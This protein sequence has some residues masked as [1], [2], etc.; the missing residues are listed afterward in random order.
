MK[1]GKMSNRRILKQTGILLACVAVGWFLKARLTPSQM[2]GAMMGAGGDPYVLVQEA[3]NKDITPAQTFIARV[4]AIND[5]NIIPQVSGYIDEV[6]F[7]EGSLVKEGDLLFVIEQDRYIAT[8]EL[9]KA[10]LE[11][12]VANFTALE[13]DYNRQKALNKQKFASEA[14]LDNAYSNML[15]AKAS[16]AEAQAN[17]DL[18]KI[19]LNHTEIRA[20][21]T[22]YIGKALITKGNYVSSSTGTLAKI[23][24]TD[25]IRIAFSVTDKQFTDF[26]Q[27]K[28]A[29]DDSVYNRIILP[30]GQNLVKKPIL[31]Y[32][33]NSVNTA[34]STIPIYIEFLNDDG[35][36]IPG[37]YVNIA[38]SKEKAKSGI[39]ISQA[40]LA[41]DENGNY[42][43]VVNKDNLV[44]QRR[45]T[46]GGIVE[47]Q[48]VVTKG[49]EDGEKVI[50][51]GL[52]KV[53][54]GQKVRTGMIANKTST[55]E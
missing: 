32:S 29:V 22:G 20:P 7:K 50:I 17:Y 48:Q 28:K 3:M 44:Q 31:Y 11:K 15:Q 38:L 47:G 30:N 40:S 27:D 13:K 12:E 42:V 9:R 8:L 10:N 34:T 35:L 6:L 16:I 41:Q 46:L 25:P 21:F 49:L 19:D 52:Q 45:V 37:G 24:Q 43:M 33:D 26:K 54:D 14:T 53:R 5:V 4:E 2:M 36:L 39:M 1:V 55:G 51:Q 18:A 23:V